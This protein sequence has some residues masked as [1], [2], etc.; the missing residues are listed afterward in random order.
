MLPTPILIEYNQRQAFAKVGGMVEAKRLLLKLAI[1][2]DLEILWSKHQQIRVSVLFN[3]PNHQIDMMARYPCKLQIINHSATKLQKNLILYTIYPKT[4]PEETCSNQGQ[5]SRNTSDI[6]GSPPF[7]YSHRRRFKWLRKRKYNR[8]QLW[9]FLRRIY[10]KRYGGWRKW[11]TGKS[12]SG[13]T[14]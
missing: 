11:R 1:L 6:C 5:G 13:Y 9:F 8:Y 2:L 3:I 12:T 7:P 14:R 10:K 4:N